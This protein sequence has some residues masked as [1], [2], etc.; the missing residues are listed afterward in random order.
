MLNVCSL[1]PN[2]P[3]HSYKTPTVLELNTTSSP[4]QIGLFDIILAVGLLSKIPFTNT[5]PTAEQPLGLVTVTAYWP[6]FATLTLEMVGLGKLETKPAGPA[7][8]Y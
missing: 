4:S 5:I 3:I 8:L 1:A 6:L 7:Q 2:G